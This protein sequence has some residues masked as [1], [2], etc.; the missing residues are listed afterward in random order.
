MPNRLQPEG[1]LGLRVEAADLDDLA[2]TDTGVPEAR[3]DVGDQGGVRR[4]G[5][6]QGRLGGRLVGLGG[7]LGGVG[8]GQVRHGLGLVAGDREGAVEDALGHEGPRDRL[9]RTAGERTEVRL[10]GI[11]ELDDEV[12]VG[13]REGAAGGRGVGAEDG[14][15]GRFD[16]LGRRQLAGQLVGVDREPLEGGGAVGLGHAVGVGDAGD[17]QL[18][19]AEAVLNQLHVGGRDG[20]GVGREARGVDDGGGHGCAS[21]AWLGYFWG[22]LVVGMEVAQG[23]KRTASSCLPC[24]L[25]I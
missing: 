24:G 21:W 7:V 9:R 22:Y 17:G 5:V 3:L 15:D 4:V 20:C 16:R 23:P 18:E 12:R 2:V 10:G 13:R 19:T 6:G 14:R 1:R 25:G 11:G 8:R